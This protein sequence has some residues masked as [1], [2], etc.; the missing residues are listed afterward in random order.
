MKHYGYVIIGNSAAGIGA[1]EAIRTQDKT[2]TI[3]IVSDE[4]YH[5][6]SR[7]LVTHYLAGQ[8]AEEKMAY[9]P[10]DFYVRKQADTTFDVGVQRIECTS[11]ELQ[12]STGEFIV[13]DRLLVA[14]GAEPV[15]PPISGRDRKGVFTFTT[16]DDARRLK[17]NLGSINEVVILGGGLIGLKTA[18][19]LI[20]CKKHVTAVELAGRILSPVLDEK[21][22]EIV[23]EFLVSRG[24]AI[25]KRHT[26]KE[27]LPR[28]RTNND[29]GGVVLDGGEKLNADAVII[30]VG[31]KPRTEIVK[32]TPIRV[33]RG[34]VVD[35]N[36]RTSVQ[37]VYAAGDVAEGYD[38]VMGCNRVI[39]IWPNAYMGGRIAGLNMAGRQMTYDFGMSMNAIDFFGFNVVS[40]GLL[41]CVDE[42]EVETLIYYNA[43]AKAYKKIILRRNRIAGIIM[44]NEILTS[45]LLV[46]LMKKALDVS[47]V[48]E[49]LLSEDFNIADLPEH[50]RREGLGVEKLQVA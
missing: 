12:L 7:P 26:I 4:P 50:I 34:V 45:G 24:I 3:L 23:E 33:N 5:T 30:A 22:S 16:L 8:V 39:P 27:I 32:G 21:A 9:R 40:A 19:A 43:P 36:M 47:Q 13:W 1:V 15:I 6:Y 38:F 10:A 49:K 17:Q 46:G 2:G 35:K 37:D 31:V 48:K 25:M 20:E 29:V 42:K 18:E 44:V 28:S 41:E 14:T 11:H